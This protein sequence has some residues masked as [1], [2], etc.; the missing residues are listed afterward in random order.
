[1]GVE[2]QALVDMRMALYFKIETGSR[3]VLAVEL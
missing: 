1:M 2:R 3:M